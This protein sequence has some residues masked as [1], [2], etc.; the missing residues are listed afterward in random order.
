MDTL[1][2]LSPVSSFTQAQTIVDTLLPPVTFASVTQR[3]ARRVLSALV[4]GLGSMRGRFAF[5]DLRA[6]WD[7]SRGAR[8]GRLR[9]L[10]AMPTIPAEAADVIDEYLARPA[11]ERESIAFEITD[12]LRDALLQAS[13]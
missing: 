13:A 11:D 5:A 7:N 4:F 8:T 10:Q 9:E 3:N 6:F 12:L 2:N 1:T